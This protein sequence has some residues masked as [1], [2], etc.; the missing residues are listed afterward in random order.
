[1]WQMNSNDASQTNA[2]TA[3]TNADKGSFLHGALSGTILACFY[4]EYG[5]LGFGFLESVYKNALAK[6]LTKAGLVFEREV[7]IDVWYEGDRVGHFK[8]DFLVEGKLILEIKA[9]QAIVDADR[10]QLLNYLSASDIEVGLLLHFGPK[11]SHQRMVYS[12][13]HKRRLRSSA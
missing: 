6:E 2:D 12:N 5:Q 3:Q 7:V 11:A 9:S 1:M 10:K 4:R 8:A 13:S